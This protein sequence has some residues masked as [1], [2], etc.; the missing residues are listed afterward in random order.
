MGIMKWIPLCLFL[1]G[2]GGAGSWVWSMFFSGEVIKE[3]VLY[4]RDDA[5]SDNRKSVEFDEDVELES[6]LAPVEFTLNSD[7][8][9]IERC[10]VC[11][12]RHAN[13]LGSD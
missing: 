8:F 5:G 13:A 12:P 11:A 9:S 2:L 3:I 1:A 7:G 10:L 6:E 4:E